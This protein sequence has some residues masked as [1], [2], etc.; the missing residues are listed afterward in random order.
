MDLNTSETN[1]KQA[2]DLT[3]AIVAMRDEDPETIE[4]QMT[5]ETEDQAEDQVED[6]A[7]N[8]AA[9]DEQAPAQE[10]AAHPLQPEM[11]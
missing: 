9:G 11:E 10:A 8:P 4:K 5:A 3:Q 6:Q 7:E 2:P 1:V